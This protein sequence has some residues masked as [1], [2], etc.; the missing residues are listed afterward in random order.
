MS[1]PYYCSEHSH[2]ALGLLE[3]NGKISLCEK[4]NDDYWGFLGPPI[5]DSS[6]SRSVVLDLLGHRGSKENI[7]DFLSLCEIKEILNLDQPKS[8]FDVDVEQHERGFHKDQEDNKIA[9]IEE[10]FQ[11]ERSVEKWLM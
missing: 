7:R 4:E 10:P 6:R 8:D 11:I 1:Y 5:Y 9:L 2:D 3:E